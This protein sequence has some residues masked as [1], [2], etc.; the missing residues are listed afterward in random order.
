MKVSKLPSGQLVT[1]V[2]GDE[3][4]RLGIPRHKMRFVGSIGPH[5]EDVLDAP[6]GQP[7]R[8]V[9]YDLIPDRDQLLVGERGTFD[10]SE[11][12]K[13]QARARDLVVRRVVN[14]PIGPNC[15][16]IG[17]YVRHGEPSSPQLNFWLG[18][19]AAFLIGIVLV[20]GAK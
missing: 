2:I 16:H 18:A 3:L 13:I 4:I 10:W 15:E 12:L 8:L 6:K 1:L 11:Q 7:A 9:H 17:S 5:G 20:S 14:R 19:A